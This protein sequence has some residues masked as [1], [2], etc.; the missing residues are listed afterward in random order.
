M[1]EIFE[2][3]D[4][5]PVLL[6][7]DN[8]SYCLAHI[9]KTVRDN[10]TATDEEFVRAIKTHIT[11]RSAGHLREYGDHVQAR[12]LE[13]SLRTVRSYASTDAE[14]LKR[15]WIGVARH[16]KQKHVEGNDMSEFLDL[17]YAKTGERK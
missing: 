5:D 6:M 12:E 11:L 17:H 9:M 4:S 3:Y 13:K 14:A 8:T 2:G 16:Y 7:L 1:S 15:Y 10:L